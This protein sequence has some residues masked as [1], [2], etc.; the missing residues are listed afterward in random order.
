VSFQ[1]NDQMSSDGFMTRRAALRLLGAALAF[2]ALPQFAFADDALAFA[3]SLYALPNLW[4]DVT[5]DDAAIAKY[6]APDL[7]ALIKENYANPDPDAALD[8]DPLVQAQDFSDVKTKFTVKSE[9][10]TAATIEVAIDNLD[11]STTVTLYLV[12]TAEGW[13]LANLQGPDGPSLADELKQLNTN[14]G[15]D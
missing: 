9:T 1:E 4:G 15:G 5:T 6:L 3:Q 2:A 14:T 10:A 8:Y 11:A 12:E 13:R 7:A